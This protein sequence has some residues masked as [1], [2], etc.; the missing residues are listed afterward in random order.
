MRPND[1]D[2]HEF[3]LTR[4]NTALLFSNELT[5]LYTLL[6]I[7]FVASLAY[8]ITFEFALVFESNGRLGR[9]FDSI[10][11]IVHRKLPVNHCI[12]DI[13]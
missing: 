9:E 1:D 13:K 2:E 8:I 4:K 6:A 10:S 12:R 11:V 3:D 5:A 7:L